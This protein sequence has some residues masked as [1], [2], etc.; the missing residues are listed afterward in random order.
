ML[1]ILFIFFVFYSSTSLLAQDS[2]AIYKI[3]SE[4][5]LKLIEGQS[6]EKSDWPR[7]KISV[8]PFATNDFGLGF[9]IQYERYIADTHSWSI[10]FPIS[11]QYYDVENASNSITDETL[12]TSYSFSISPGIRKSFT[13]D[14]FDLYL[15]MR[16]FYGMSKSLH[17]EGFTWAPGTYRQFTRTRQFFAPLLDGGFNI[18]ISPKFSFNMEV[19]GGIQLFQSIKDNGVVNSSDDWLLTGGGLIGFGYNF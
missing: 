12:A 2:T 9:Q 7:N 17:S 15:G 6:D 11:Y 5:A 14:H 19:S 16:L 13:F 4:A 18:F 8:Y 10:I 3:E 1:R